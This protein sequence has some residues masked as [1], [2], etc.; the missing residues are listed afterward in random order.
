MSSWVA[1]TMGAS[2]TEEPKCKLI[3]YG[4]NVK[5]MHLQYCCASRFFIYPR[6]VRNIDFLLH[7]KPSF[8]L[9]WSH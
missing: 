3:D 6:L 8:E 2:Q 7:V 1:T 4:L 9:Y 5:L